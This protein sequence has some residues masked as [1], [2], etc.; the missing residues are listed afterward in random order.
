MYKH[1]NITR[2]TRTIASREAWKQF[3]LE[4]GFPS[5]AHQWEIEGYT[6]WKGKP[7]R[8]TPKSWGTYTNTVGLV[9]VYCSWAHN[10]TGEC[11]QLN[12]HVDQVTGSL[13]GAAHW[14][15][16]R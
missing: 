1:F 6:T 7:A 16:V 8:L 14:L 9:T 2:G 13:V 5:E 3:M 15:K 11:W 4:V 10:D 12:Q